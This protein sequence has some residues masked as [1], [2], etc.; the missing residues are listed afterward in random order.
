MSGLIKYKPN[1]SGTT[2]KPETDA[3]IERWIQA[4]A[5]RAGG[6]PP[7]YRNGSAPVP[8][9]GGQQAPIVLDLPRW[10]TIHDGARWM[11]HYIR[12]PN[13]LYVYQGSF[14]IETFHEMNY[15]AEGMCKLPSNFRHGQEECPCGTRIP[16]WYSGS[17]WCPRC[18]AYVCYGRTSPSGYFQ[19]RVSCGC[20][21]Q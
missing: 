4:A 15:A 1:A 10:C 14:W 3:A 7:P 12:Q 9:P 17:V 16:P 18:V 11:A 2:R 6:A 13:G 8:A 20:E 21:G 5:A 19:C